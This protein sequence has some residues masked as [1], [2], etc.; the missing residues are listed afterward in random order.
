VKVLQ[1]NGVAYDNRGNV[2]SYIGYGWMTLNPRDPDVQIDLV[3]QDGFTSRAQLAGVDQRAGVV[4]LRGSQDLSLQASGVVRKESYEDIEKKA[5]YLVDLDER[6]TVRR[7]NLNYVQ[8]KS[9]VLKGLASILFVGD[10]Q[11][12][13]GQLVFNANGQFFG[14]AS[15]GVPGGLM[16]VTPT[17]RL[18]ADVDKIIAS[19]Q[20][21]P[22]P[23]LGFFVDDQPAGSANNGLV[24]RE[25]VPGSPADASGIRRGDLLLKVAGEEIGEVWD[26]LRFVRS[27][28]IGENLKFQV[29]RGGSISTVPVQ[30]AARADVPE[31]SPSSLYLQFAPGASDSGAPQIELSEVQTIG[32]VNG[33]VSAMVAPPRLGFVG[34]DLT[35]Q[36]GNYFGVEGGRGVLIISVAPGSLAER[37][38]MKAGDVI[39]ALNEDP[40]LNQLNFLRVIERHAGDVSWSLRLMRERKPV[41][42]K[43]T[44]QPNPS[45]KEK[46][47]A[48]PEE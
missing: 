42:V 20:D 1:S 40:A 18:L 44:L 19:G 31:S 16:G 27:V 38:G 6:E 47:A 29:S 45:K 10:Q 24:V 35:P 23:W 13:Q 15:G 11:V 46:T 36:L 30:V 17:S 14:S 2:V 12:R 7:V 21:T 48:P 26:F 43:I 22:A 37:H 5:F 8:K 4:I 39:V 25:V 3:R 34:D 33:Q 32:R 28:N 41:E 9:G